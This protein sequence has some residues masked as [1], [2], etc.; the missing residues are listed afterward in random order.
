MTMAPAEVA[1]L[2]TA[3]GLSQDQLADMLSVNVRTVRSWESGRQAVSD[4]SGAA[5]LGLV[6][7]QQQLVDQMLSDGSPVA[8]ARDTPPDAAP[9]RGWHL[10]AAGRAMLAQPDL[11]VEWA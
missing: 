10:A 6:E 2:R 7:R 4:G 5:L 3:M 1:A 11:M 8:I 9:P